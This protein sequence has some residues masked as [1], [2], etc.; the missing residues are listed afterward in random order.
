MIYPYIEGIEVK[1]T[2]QN[3]DVCSNCGSCDC[4]FPCDSVVKCYTESTEHQKYY[5]GACCNDPTMK[6]LGTEITCV[7]LCECGN[8]PTRYNMGRTVNKYCHNCG[9]PDLDNA[10]NSDDCNKK[11]LEWLGMCNYFVC[12][13]CGVKYQIM[14]V[15]TIHCTLIPFTIINN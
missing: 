4:C 11:T 10:N 1:H 5:C 12:D 14:C 7:E 13:K 6:Q 8:K 15:D 3:N 2:I 9:D